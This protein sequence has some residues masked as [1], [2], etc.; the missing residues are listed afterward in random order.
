MSLVSHMCAGIP[1]ASVRAVVALQGGE[2]RAG[3]SFWLLAAGGQWIGMLTE[4]SP[5]I[6]APIGEPLR[7][8]SC[9]GSQLATV[10][11]ELRS[12]LWFAGDCARNLALCDLETRNPVAIGLTIPAKL[13]GIRETGGSTVSFEGLTLWLTGLSGAGK[14][15]L[16]RALESRLSGNFRVELLDADVVRTHICKGLGFS[17]ED[18]NENV[19]RLA[20]TAKQLADTGAVVIVSAISPYRAG[21]D[22]ARALIG[23]FLE[24]Y[25]NAPLAVC[26]RRDV[27]GLYKRARRGELNAFTGIDDPYEPPLRPD[28]ECIT[29]MESP[30]ESVAKIV[31][32]IEERFRLRPEV[33]SATIGEDRS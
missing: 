10:T 26:E 11:F 20:F 23:N 33:V 28:V 1:N 19:L 18:R 3:E 8:Q 31:A 5:V 2:P 9:S 14:T 27:K 4:I 29:E 30:E 21:R 12:S 7:A 24:V 6:L 15:T 17:K 16:S 32:V 25:V 22:A 13:P